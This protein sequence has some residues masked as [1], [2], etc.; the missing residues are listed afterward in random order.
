ML[1]TDIDLK[2]TGKEEKQIQITFKGG[3][4]DM[5]R[6]LRSLINALYFDL[7]RVNPLAAEVLKMLLFSELHPDSPLWRRD[8]RSKGNGESIVINLG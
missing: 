8:L 6:D 4:D 5:L 2:R 1:K 3:A 7:K